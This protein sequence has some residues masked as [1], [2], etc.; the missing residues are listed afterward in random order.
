MNG[1]AP[2][3]TPPGIPATPSAAPHGAPRRAPLGAASFRRLDSIRS[4]ILT[5]ALLATL[6]PSALALG[7]S[8]VQNRRLLEAQLTRDLV[9]R[10]TQSAGAVG[11]WLK[12]RQY[13]LRVFAGSEEVANQLDLSAGAPIGSPTHGRLH[14]YLLSLHERFADFQQLMVLD[15]RGRVLATSLSAATPVRL[16]DG[17]LQS[18]RSDSRFVGAPYASP[19]GRTTVLVAVPVRRADGRVLGA[20]AAELSLSEV[21][22]VLRS[23][24]RGTGAN[25]G[26]LWVLDTAGLPVTRSESAATLAREALPRPTLERLVRRE[27]EAVQ[28]KSLAGHDVVGTLERVPGTRWV[29]LAETPADAAFAQAR[30]FRNVALAVIVLMLGIAATAAWRFGLLIVRPLD[31]LASAAREVAAG[32]LAVDLPPGGSGEVG[33]LTAVFN[34]MV[35]RLREGRRALDEINETLRQKNEELERLSITDGLTGLANHRALVH[36]LDEEAERFRRNGRQFCVVMADVD[37]FKQYNDGFGHLAGDEALRTVAAIMRQSTRAVD[38]VARYGGE[39]F[40]IVMPETELDGAMH[41]AER[42]RAAVAAATFPG[43]PMTMSIGVAEF[44]SQADSP[45]TIIAAADQ[46]LY[47]A[48]REGRDR[49][50]S[51]A[52]A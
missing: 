5:F 29:V 35:S 49:V 14:D 51:G 11:V 52:K 26:G 2:D 13:D 17:W 38:F 25:R 40:A 3:I 32:D 22:G 31:R 12:E 47:R 20:L 19:R 24:A 28:Y 4:R 7:L 10:S 46:A 48:K 44:P 16:P 36:R 41:V 23:Y 6:V 37:R 15:T 45:T 30:R 21:R 27:G 43:R 1:D 34:H 9:S 50:V 33:S 42:I 8:Y 18:L 39:E